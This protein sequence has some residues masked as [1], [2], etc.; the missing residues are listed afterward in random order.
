MSDDLYDYLDEFAGEVPTVKQELKFQSI[1]Y[2]APNP[3][4]MEDGVTIARSDKMS[5]EAFPEQNLDGFNSYILDLNLNSRS[6]YIDAYQ[7][8]KAAPPDCSSANGLNP[9]KP[10]NLNGQVITNC[11]L[12]PMNKRGQKTVKGE[13]K[14]ER[15]TIVHG[16]AEFE[17]GDNPPLYV[18]WVKRLSFTSRS[19]AETLNN[20]LGAP[21]KLSTGKLAYL[22]AYMYKVYVF[23]AQTDKSDGGIM[24]TWGF[25]VLPEFASKETATKLRELS[26]LLQGMLV[27]PPPPK[28]TSTLEP[29]QITGAPTLTEVGSDIELDASD[30]PF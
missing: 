24:N 5:C 13:P 8:G 10:F 9:D 20:K 23:A 3:R 4:K 17:Q 7:A 27:A 1:I 29:L 14:C 28:L 2:G 30:V 6:L 26:E 18:P 22:P 19:A 25:K 11:N 16:V 21:Y 12:C 15:K